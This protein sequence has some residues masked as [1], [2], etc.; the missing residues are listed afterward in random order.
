VARDIIKLDGHVFVSMM[1]PNATLLL[2]ITP[3]QDIVDDSFMSSRLVGD[4]LLAGS[5]RDC[6]Y[7][8]ATTGK[9]NGYGQVNLCGGMVS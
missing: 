2:K 8:V 1:V 6:L 3:L 7:Q 4:K 9:D 5:P